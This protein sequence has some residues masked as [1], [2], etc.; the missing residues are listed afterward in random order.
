MEQEFGMIVLSGRHTRG[1]KYSHVGARIKILLAR[2]R[3]KR[4]DNASIYAAPRSLPLTAILQ[5]G[6]DG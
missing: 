1:S 4:C 6:G 5:A 3:H 2:F